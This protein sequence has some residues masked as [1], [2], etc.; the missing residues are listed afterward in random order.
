MP[1][2]VPL[3]TG[4]IGPQRAPREVVHRDEDEEEA[5]QS[6]D[7]GF[8][9][10]PL[11][12]M[13]L[14]ALL[15]IGHIGPPALPLEVARDNGNDEEE[16]PLD[17][18]FGPLRVNLTPP[19]RRETPPGDRV[20]AVDRRR[21]RT[22]PPHPST[23]RTTPYMG[24][25]EAALVECFGEIPEGLD[26]WGD[27]G[28]NTPSTISADEDEVSLDSSQPEASRPSS[29][30]RTPPHATGP[31][32]DESASTISAEENE[33]SRDS[34]RT[35][36]SWSPPPRW[37][38]PSVAQAGP[39]PRQSW[40]PL[41]A[42]PRSPPPSYED[43][44]GPGPFTGPHTPARCAAVI[45][46]HDPRPRLPTIAELAAEQARRK[47]EDLREELGIP[48]A[49]PPPAN[50][51]PPPTPRRRAR[52]RNAPW[53]DGPPSSSDESSLDTVEDT[54]NPPRWVPAPAERTTPNSRLPAALLRRIQGRLAIPRRRTTR[55]LEEEAS[56]RFR[57]QIN[58]NGKVIVT[59]QPSRRWDGV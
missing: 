24:E 34:G 20:P 40:T 48:P 38:S 51:Q 45:S 14:Q 16:V 43:I 4:L 47:A 22:T 18:S 13:P 28:D 15:R 58:R 42:Q 33:T 46:R 23:R 1:P 8:H 6:D 3:R 41:T 44:F 49:V 30:R 26:D 50:G 25:V 27:T 5:H 19:Q 52:R 12:G 21:R 10:A 37:T 17:H 36:V 11:R 2:L 32:D 56:Q 9:P 39:S 54:T 59:L 31:T 57:V 35:H 29:P 55:I 53:A 7:A